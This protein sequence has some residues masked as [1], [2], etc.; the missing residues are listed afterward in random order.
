MLMKCNGEFYKQIDGA[1]MGSPFSH[2]LA[3]LFMEDFEDKVLDSAGFKPAVFWRYSDDTFVVWLHG[4]D[5]LHRFLENIN[6]IRAGIKFTM[7][8]EKDVCLPFLDV[9]VPCKVDSTFGHAVYCTPIHANPY[10][11]ASGG[12]H[13]SQTIGFLK[14]LLLWAHCLLSIQ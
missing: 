13:P 14:T 11:L 8:T 4:M 7:E 10:L 3:N 1:A 9:V 6:C 5:E 12:H 2:L